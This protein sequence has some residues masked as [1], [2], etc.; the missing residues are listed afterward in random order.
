M[1]LDKFLNDQG[2][3]SR[4]ELKAM[5]KNGRVLVDNEPCKDPARHI[6]P[7]KQVV[8][9]DQ[10]AV[11]YRKEVYLMLNKPAGVITA[12]EDKRQQTVLNLLPEPWCNMDIFPVGRLDKD[13]EGLLILTSNG[14]L[15]HNLLSPKKHVVKLYEAELNQYP[16][17]SAI[18]AF[19]IGVVLDDGYEALP[20]VLRF[21]S[22]VK[23]V[24]AQVEVFEGKFHQVKRMFKAV[25]VMVVRLKRLKMGE[26]SLD[27]TLKPGEFRELTPAEIQSLGGAL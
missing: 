26:V 17:D 1:R 13:T 16:G 10:A 9:V 3:A 18:E 27:E 5:I 11:P 4:S 21:V 22:K 25:G 2:I 15:A 14:I 24:V 12:T 8:S 20:A 23:P 6:D 7:E 19:K